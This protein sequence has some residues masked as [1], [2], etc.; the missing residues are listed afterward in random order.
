[1]RALNGNNSHL[2][3]DSEEMLFRQIQNKD[4]EILSLKAEIQNCD[5]RLNELTN[6]Y[7]SNVHDYQQIIN[8]IKQENL[9]LA[10]QLQLEKAKNQKLISDNNALVIQLNTLSKAK[11]Y[12]STLT[13]FEEVINNMQKSYTLQLNDKEKTIYEVKQSY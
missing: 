9:L 1:M 8:D 3:N 10:E 7:D 4:Y 2:G 13:N 12:S 11:Q 5:S 6:K